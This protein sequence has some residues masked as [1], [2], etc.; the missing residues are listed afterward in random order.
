[1]MR[2]MFRRLFALLSALSLLLCLAAAALWVNPPRTQFHSHLGSILLNIRMVPG[3]GF[4]TGGAALTIGLPFREE[5]DG[6][7]PLPSGSPHILV[8]DRGGAAHDLIALRVW[9]RDTITTTWVT[10]HRYHAEGTRMRTVW[11][12]YRTAAIAMGFLPACWAT[13][14]FWY[15]RARRSVNRA[16]RCAMCGYDLRATPDRCPECGTE[17][18]PAKVKG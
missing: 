18:A 2:A 11:F 10:P 8:G 4:G 13:S 12:R 17:P 3:I 6:D 16:G 5:G 7:E 1:M 9:S 14:A 15:G